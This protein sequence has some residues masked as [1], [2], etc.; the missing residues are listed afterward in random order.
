MGE[1]NTI[2]VN[3]AR[4]MPIFP[5]ESVV[6]LPQQVLHLHIFEPRYQ[7]MVEHALDGPGQIAMAIFEGQRWKQEYHGRPPIRQAVCVGQIL[8]HERL[9]DGRYN[10]LL[11]GVCRA[12]IVRPVPPTAGRLY[13]EA[14]LEPVGPSETDESELAPQRQ[15]LRRTL[16]SPELAD[17]AAAA[18]VLEVLDDEDIPTTAVLEL[19]SFTLVQDPELKYALLAEGDPHRRAEMVLA[20]LEHLRG[21]IR[22]A[23]AQ[24]V[25][26]LPRGCSWN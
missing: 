26:D 21:L 8:Q 9:P 17:L 23:R 11:Q 15:R 20:E 24:R 5:L 22:Q 1:E 7:Q 14:T 4:P 25:G 16:A 10:V 2:R 3:F 13:R 6:L 12:R 19:V 18:S